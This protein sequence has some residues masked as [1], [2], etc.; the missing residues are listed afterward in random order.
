MKHHVLKML[1]LAAAIAT[2]AGAPAMAETTANAIKAPARKQIGAPAPQMDPSLLVLNADGA[3]LEGTKLTLTGVATTAILFAD[4]PVRAA[5]HVP[6]SFV[7]DEWNKDET[8]AKDPPNAT[9]SVF[10]KDGKDVKDAVVVLTSPAVA[11]SDLTFEVKVI[12][13]EIAG[14]D[15]A[16]ALFIDAFYAAYRGP[17]GR[18]GAV[19]VHGAWYGAPAGA[20][21]GAAV[22]GAVVGAA[23][24]TAARPV[25]VAPPPYYPPAPYPYPYAYPPAPYYAPY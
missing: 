21:A 1:G 24:A 15:G 20:V 25:Y 8:F 23:A 11:G 10:S 16:A 17:Y 22:A 6:I 7:V 12:E 14:A 2:L 5:G 13:G 3:T 19:G 18:Y 4:R 9:I